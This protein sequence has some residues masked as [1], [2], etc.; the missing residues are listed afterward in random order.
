MRHFLRAHAVSYRCM[1][2]RPEGAKEEMAFFH[3]A[4]ISSERNIYL[5]KVGVIEN[6]MEIDFLF[7]TNDINYIYKLTIEIQ[8]LIQS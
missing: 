3:F 8:L 2:M 4:N 1:G 6:I 7:H 5:S